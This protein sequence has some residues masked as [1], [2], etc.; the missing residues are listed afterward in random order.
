SWD[1]QPTRPR[2]SSGPRANRSSRS[3]ILGGGHPATARF[4]RGTSDTVRRGPRHRNVCAYPDESS[5]KSY[6]PP[7]PTPAGPRSR[8]TLQKRCAEKSGGPDNV[9]VVYPPFVV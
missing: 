4:A 8:P 2:P 9:V 6:P 5:M 7:E 1:R 3:S